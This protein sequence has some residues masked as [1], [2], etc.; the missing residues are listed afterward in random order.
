MIE[1]MK[2]T[3]ARA[4]FAA[5]SHQQLQRFATF[6]KPAV[7]EKFPPLINR[8]DDT[9]GVKPNHAV[10]PEPPFLRATACS[11]FSPQIPIHPTER[12][13]P[14]SVVTTSMPIEVRKK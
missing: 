10:S 7:L 12:T 4:L 6:L 13:M 1:D 11:F 14:S 3:Q 2:G 5:Q 9:L 8:G